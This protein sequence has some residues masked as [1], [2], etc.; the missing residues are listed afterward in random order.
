MART[1]AGRAAGPTTTWAPT[2]TAPPVSVPVTT[3][4]APL[5]AKTRSTQRR[6]RPR[7]A[8]W[9]VVA[10]SRS[11]AVPSSSSPR[12]VGAATSTT[13]ESCRN[14]PA[15]VVGEVE[16]GD[17]QLLVVDQVD[18]GEGD[19]TPGDAE[20]LEDAQVLL[21]LR[22]PALGGRHDEQ[23]GVD[24]SDPREHVLDEADVTGHVDEG[25]ASPARERG[26]GEAEV[27]GQARGASPP[28]SGQGRCR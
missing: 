22:L 11:S 13:G 27:D 20:E 25:D 12:P 8:A 14:E 26:V 28:R 6:G 5:A 7:S 10:S 2:A 3:V 18:L 21:G 1:R 17:L 24:R 16:V 23:A 15:E 4:P 9:G 19:H